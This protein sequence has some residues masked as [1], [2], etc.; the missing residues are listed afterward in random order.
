MSAGYDL[1]EGDYARRPLSDDEMW[2]AFAYLFSSKS[3]NDTSYKYGFLKAI[4]DNLYNVDENL[5]LS[6]D[7]LFSKFAE[8][9]WNLVLK[10]HILQKAPTKN[11]RMSSLERV[12]LDSKERYQI[13]E[14]VPFESLTAEMI[15]DICKKVKQKCKE[16][17]VG[18]LYA[19]L[20]GLFYGFSKPSEWIQ[21]NPIM[22][23]FVCKH[24]VAI[25]KLNYYE[26]AKFLERVNDTDSVDHLLSKI[27][28]SAKRNN[29][30]YFRDILFEEFENK[31]FYCGKKVSLGH[32]EVDHFIP[33]SFIKDDNLWNFVLACP[34]CNNKKRDKLANERYL[35]DLVARNTSIVIE[36]HNGMRN[37][38][39]KRLLSIYNWAL[40]NGYDE[41]WTPK[42]K[43]VL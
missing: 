13:D 20:G 26:W 10:H 40:K 24:K 39:E 27:D 15:I 9:Y 2:S 37:Y 21:I 23:E 1:K 25:E 6:F 8:V 14:G 18:A 22:Y 34:E 12:L 42:Q 38:Q 36:T 28:E 19:D 35:H 29:L 31:C 43:A 5:V 4:L 11:N 17:V 3:H 30:S 32:V 33:W 41:I 16:N 7:Q